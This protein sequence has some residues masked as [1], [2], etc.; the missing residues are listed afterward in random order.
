[1]CIEVLTSEGCLPSGRKAGILPSLHVLWQE[2]HISQ[3]EV[4]TEVDPC[5]P[6]SSDYRKTTEE[7]CRYP[8]VLLLKHLTLGTQHHQL[9]L[10]TANMEDLSSLPNICLT[11]QDV[12]PKTGGD[13]A[14]L[15]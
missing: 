5:L 4:K 9:I 2:A 14:V 8:E 6:R 1:M 15:I 12:Q 3:L 11:C 13:L 10:C 7:L